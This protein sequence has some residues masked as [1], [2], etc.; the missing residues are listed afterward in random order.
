MLDVPREL[1]QISFSRFI[2]RAGINFTRSDI[3]EV[4]VF[5]LISRLGLFDITRQIKNY[6][7]GITY[8]YYFFS[9]LFLSFVA[10]WGRNLSINRSV[11]FYLGRIVRF[12][13]WEHSSILFQTKTDSFYFTKFDFSKKE[14]YWAK[15]DGVP[16]GAQLDSSCDLRPP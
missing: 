4:Q 14:K 2:G 5:Q 16:S 12:I 1:R 11:N 6:L 10:W 8:L 9:P 13:S 15:T 7:I 3:G